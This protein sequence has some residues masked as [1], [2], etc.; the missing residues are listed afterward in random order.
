MWQ[1]FVA[2]PLALVVTLSAA[3][4]DAQGQMAGTTQ[5]V[6][7][8]SA[9]APPSSVLRQALADVQKT[10]A[11]LNISRWR[12]SRGARIAAQ[13]D[14]DSIQHDL[15]QTLPSLLAPADASPESIPRSFAVYRNVDA[16]YDVLLRVS[17]VADFAAPDDEA[18]AIT[19]SL[20]Q[21]HASRDRLGDAILRVSQQHEAQI[22]EF[23]AALRA[24]KAEQ[25][26]P[27]KEIIIDDGPVTTSHTRRKTEQKEVHKHY[28]EKHTVAKPAPVTPKTMSQ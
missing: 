14:V 11:D 24:A 19:S 10:T 12:T 9:E 23:E 25:P 16:L 1:R 18:Q 7:R 4:F 20:Q 6:T 8:A 21:L 22:R 2:T 26:T 17:E 28:E 5:P 27:R 13:Q 3:T 15:S